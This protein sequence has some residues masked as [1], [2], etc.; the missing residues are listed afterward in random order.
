MR[1][2]LQATKQQTRL[3][4][5]IAGGLIKH[6]GLQM[7]S[8]PAPA[9]VELVANAWDAMAANVKITLP[10]NRPLKPDDEIIVEDDGHGMSYAEC[11]DRYLV[12]GYDRRRI[13]GDR[14]RPYKKIRPRK[15]L[16]RKG[17]GKLAGFGI[18]N[19]VEVR[20]VKNGKITHFLMDFKEMTK[21]SK[22]VR[23]YE[24]KLLK[25]NG[26][27]TGESPG[28]RVTLRDLKITRP[29]NEAKFKSSLARR[30]AILSDPQFLVFVNG[31][32]VKKEELKFQF[33]YPKQKG[34]WKSEKIKDAG[35]IK[36]WMGF[37]EKPIQDEEARGIVVLARGKLAQAP[38]FFDISGGLYGQHGMQYLTGEVQAD[39]LDVTNGDD[40]IAT[41][42]ASVLWDDSSVA[43]ALKEWGQNKI[44]ELLKEWVGQ[45]QTEKRERPEI[46][47]YLALSERL[48]ERERKIFQQFVYKVTSIPQIDKEEDKEILDELIKFG[49]NA[50]TNQH[51]LEVIK[52][53][54]LASPQD[55][56]RITAV[57]S[58]WDIIEAISAAQQVRGRVEIIRKFKEMIEKGI[59]EKPDMQDYIKEHPWLINPVWAPL[60]HEKSL[61][62]ILVKEF[63]AKKTQSKDG[64]QRLDF[65]CLAASNQWE[66]VDLKRPGQKVGRKELQQIQSYVA[67]LREYSKKT[68]HPEIRV[69]VSSI[70]GILV[71]SDIADGLAS[72]IESL[73]RD[74]IHVLTW[75]DLLR[76]TEMLHKEFLDVIRGRAPA[77]DPRIKALYENL[78]KKKSKKRN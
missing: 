62:T 35:T 28:T 33:R 6:L 34:S 78:I 29:I 7:Y 5:K 53:I 36:W 49:Y 69:N 37:T 16:A 43:A 13:D 71:Y 32:Q 46:K 41:D 57:L 47:K 77:D 67:F 11:N 45:R 8:G 4:M 23:E 70:N 40:L 30:F 9:I 21:G 25:D 63:R 42:R 61:D 75:D 59:P 17:I 44:R 66:V 76:R 64:R 50:L 3:K 68:S 15:L 19:I 24:P 48:P 2:K 65:F 18:A 10:T 52:Q 39:F 38:W 31:T 51:F 12:V 56:E 74:G 72:L 58:E 26:K 60:S 73:T 20:T 54:N 1:Q 55:L 14:T 22:Y 27:S